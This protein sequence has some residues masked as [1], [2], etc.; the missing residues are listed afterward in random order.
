M[1]GYYPVIIQKIPGDQCTD[2][3]LGPEIVPG[4]WGAYRGVSMSPE[5]PWRQFN[6]HG[7]YPY[8]TAP[9]LAKIEVAAAD[10][11]MLQLGPYSRCN[12][13]RSLEATMRYRGYDPRDFDETLLPNSEFIKS[14][15]S[16]TKE[17][18]ALW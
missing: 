6:H 5:W 14:I 2:W 16:R 15:R 11:F 7:P 12:N 1:K 3:Q 13:L 8:A 4:W 17:G 9:T 10:V 18:E